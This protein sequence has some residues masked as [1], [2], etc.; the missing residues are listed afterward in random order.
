MDLRSDTRHI[1][2][3]EEIDFEAD[4]SIISSPGNR[5]TLEMKGTANSTFLKNRIG[6]CILHPLQNCA[7]HEC[8]I[9]HPDG[10]I[11]TGRFPEEIS[12]H[13]PFRNIRRMRWKIND[14]LEARLQFDG[15][16]F[17]TEDQRNWTDASYKTYSTPLDQPYPVEVDE[18]HFIISA[19]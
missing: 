15:D 11:S 14:S 7:G 16:I 18:R 8:I 19:G 9:T 1:T 13:Q 12:P 3:Y 2:V 17:E 6:F 4:I 5:L 10:S